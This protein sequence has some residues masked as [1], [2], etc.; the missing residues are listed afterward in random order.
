MCGS[1]AGL[2]AKLIIYPM[3]VVKKRLQVQGFEEARSKFGAIREYSGLVNC[4]QCLVREEGSKGLY[5][6]LYPSLIKAA[7]I[8]GTMFCFYDQICIVIVS[9]RSS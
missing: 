9:L 7:L 5:K 8:S 3:D 2:L 4:I 6:G 1:G